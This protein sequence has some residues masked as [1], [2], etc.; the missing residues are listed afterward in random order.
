MQWHTTRRLNRGKAR[1]VVRAR[2]TGDAIM[3]LASVSFRSGISARSSFGFG[4][5]RAGGVGSTLE[6]V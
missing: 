3:P 5:F 6:Q 2:F 4:Q 1:G